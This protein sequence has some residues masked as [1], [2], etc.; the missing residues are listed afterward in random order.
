MSDHRIHLNLPTTATVVGLGLAVS[1]VSSTW[2]AARAY[3]SRADAVDKREQTM[4]VKGSTR[5]RI[6]ADR[7]VWHIDVR[8]EN[9]ELPAAFATLDEGT[10]RV[11]K[12]LTEQGFKPDEVGLGPIQTATHYVRD[13]KGVET[14]E[15]SDY[16]LTRDIGVFTP[17]V[18]RVNRSVGGV[19]QLIQDGVLVI[20]GVPEYYYTDLPKLRLELL[21]LASK[22]ART[23][24][25][26]I[27]KN[28]SGRVAEVRSAYMGVLQITQPFSTETSGE[29][30]YDTTTID[31]DV[32][33]VVTVTFRIT[34]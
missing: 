14:R 22:D 19:T 7:G 33:A 18:D 5:K 6:R 30:M 20:S 32:Q 23:R 26:E 21:G 11:Q 9:K 8:G 13:S 4:C 29:G 31:K 16:T 15:V 1:F 28:V 17:D 2:V 10:K 12:F 3:S 25:D 27:A 34:S 24:A